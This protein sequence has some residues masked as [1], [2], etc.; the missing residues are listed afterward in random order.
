M[1]SPV[2][3]LPLALVGVDIKG[4]LKGAADM[5]AICR[6]ESLAHNPALMHA[7]VQ[8]LMQ[9]RKHKPIAVT[10]AYSQRLALLADWYAQLLAESIGK[11]RS[12]SGADI[13]AGPTPVKA[14]GVTDQ[15][16]QVQLYTEGPFDKWFT[17][18]A[19]DEPDHAVEIPPAFEDLEA[20]AYLGGRTLKQLFQAERDGTR[21]ALCQA[22]RPNASF[23]LT[24]V[25]P[26]Q[27][28]QLLQLLQVSVAV[29][30]EH[31]DV[32]AFDQPGVEA[33]KAAAHA[34]MGRAGYEQLRS[35][36]EAAAERGSRLA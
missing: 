7:A 14:V 12:R 2:G 30:G 5:D 6:N 33:G 28:G 1:L 24:K 35:G 8:W 27:V 36:I 13:F 18:L 19:V 22:G 29:M 20:V 32:D 11:R 26:H 10:L 21:V 16:S 31:Y 9:T 25:E 15:H 34:L 23:W 4:V 3:L 17:L